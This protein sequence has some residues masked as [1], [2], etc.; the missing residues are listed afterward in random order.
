MQFETV[1]DLAQTGYKVWWLIPTF[2]PVMV[3]IG[4]FTLFFPR[5]SAVIL[6]V[7]SRQRQRLGR[8]FVGA[9]TIFM[10]GG[11]AV[12]YA[13][14]LAARKA[15]ISGDYAVVEG[16]VTGFAPA[17]NPREGNP[18]ERFTVAGQTFEYS[19]YF[20]TGGFNDTRAYL[21]RNGIYVRVTH[22]GNTILRLEIAR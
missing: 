9:G 21:I 22:K 8:A 17:Q 14:Y 20:P 3:G 5:A 7:P 13:N 10:V 18:T 12:T 16:T 4:A 6:H 15:L 11:F 19:D 1:F 2:G